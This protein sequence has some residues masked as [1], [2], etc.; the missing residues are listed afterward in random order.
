MDDESISGAFPRFMW[1]QQVQVQPGLGLVGH[2]RR[3]QSR[4]RHH[5]LGGHGAR[6]MRCLAGL[7]RCAA[8]MGSQWRWK[9]WVTHGNTV[10]EKDEPTLRHMVIDHIY[11][12]IYIYHIFD[13][14][15]D[16]DI[17]WL[18][19][20][21]WVD[22]S[23]FFPAVGEKT[24]HRLQCTASVETVATNDSIRTGYPTNSYMVIVEE[25]P[26]GG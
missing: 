18:S 5:R 11:C 6:S 10:T 8:E 25:Y 2:R 17:L 20:C 22:L 13:D 23:I 4:W 14:T 9:R 26:Y 19:I 12:N 16:Y 24:V 15:W 1:T 21:Q 7:P 3:R